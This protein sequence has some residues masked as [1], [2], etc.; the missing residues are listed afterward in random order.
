MSR[1][2]YDQISSSR[3]LIG[4]TP[5]S[6]AEGKYSTQTVPTSRRLCLV[7]TFGSYFSF[8]LFLGLALGIA[9]GGGWYYAPAAIM[10]IFVPLL[11]AISGNDTAEFEQSDFQKWQIR[12]MKFSPMAFTLIYILALNYIAATFTSLTL[13]EK[14]LVTFSMGLIGSVAFSAIHEIIHKNGFWEKAIGRAGLGFLCYPH[15]EVEHL[16]SHHIIAATDKDGS[17]GWKEENIYQHLIRAIPTAFVTSLPHDRNKHIPKLFLLSGIIAVTY[18]LF[19]GGGAVVYFF[20]QA[21]IAICVLHILTFAQHFGAKRDR[22]ENGKYS[23]MTAA[24]SWNAYQRFSNYLTFGVQRHADH[25]RSAMK[26]FYLLKVDEEAPQLPFG[27]PMMITIALI[28]PLWKS[29]MHRRL[30][31]HLAAQRAAAKA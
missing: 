21:F 29:L 26:P 1:Q 4:G 20:V 12:A 6:G 17:T 25:H 13:L 8:S 10:M 3:P 15:F 23:R 22:L 28:P 16:Y 31:A 5:L 11:D 14:V 27:Y 7:Q 30:D 9:F 19:F 18:G 24:H 2:K